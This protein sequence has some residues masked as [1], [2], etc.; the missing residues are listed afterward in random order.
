MIRPKKLSKALREFER[1]YK[2]LNHQDT[3][4]TK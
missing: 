1:C 2:T 4:H 3:E